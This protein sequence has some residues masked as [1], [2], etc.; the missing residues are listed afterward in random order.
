MSVVPPRP[1]RPART[2]RARRARPHQCIPHVPRAPDA[3]D[4][5]DRTRRSPRAA[6][7]SAMA[8]AS[9]KR[10]KD[11]AELEHGL[12]HNGDIRL[13]PTSTARSYARPRSRR[14][15]CAPITSTGHAGL[16]ATAYCLA[17]PRPQLQ[18]NTSMPP[19]RATAQVRRGRRGSVPRASTVVAPSRRGLCATTQVLRDLLVSATT[20]LF[21]RTTS[22]RTAADSPRRHHALAARRS[23]CLHVSRARRVRRGHRGLLAALRTSIDRHTAR[24]FTAQPPANAATAATPPTRQA[25]PRH[26]AHD[27]NCGNRNP[28]PTSPLTRMEVEEEQW[29]QHFP[30]GARTPQSFSSLQWLHGYTRLPSINTSRGLLYPAAHTASGHH[31]G[32]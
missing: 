21:A 32:H 31:T 25:R 30:A 1:A 10:R 17:P 13:L 3:P 12:K 18:R 26:Q 29:R 20:V 4:E 14:V 15:Q 11:V 24:S 19:R 7:V 6:S 23:R 22:H 2:R 28:L 16:T 5:P 27:T 8:A 9:D